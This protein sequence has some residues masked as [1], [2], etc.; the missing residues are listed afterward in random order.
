[1]KEGSKV[2]SHLLARPR[3]GWPCSPPGS[4]S[5]GYSHRTPRAAREFSPCPCQ[6][7]HDSA[8]LSN[9]P[10]LHS[11]PVAVP[12]ETCVCEA[13]TAPSPA[14]ASRRLG[15]ARI[16]TGSRPLPCGV[17]GLVP[18]PRGRAANGEW[19]SKRSLSPHQTD[20][21]LWVTLFPRSAGRASQP[22]CPFLSPAQ[23]RSP[24]PTARLLLPAGV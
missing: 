7:D 8:K 2:L 6:S 9:L 24:G 4:S 15:H 22:P 12:V 13:P 23:G 18:L 5:A 1:M 20:T 21:T 19:V 16:W 17:E 11:G 3:V 14:P 10:A